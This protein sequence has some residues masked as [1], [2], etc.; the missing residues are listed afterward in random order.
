[1]CLIAVNLHDM[2]TKKSHILATEE[3]IQATGPGLG[4]LAREQQRIFPLCQLLVGCTLMLLVLQ[5]GI[6]FYLGVIAPHD[7]LS[8]TFLSPTA[9]GAF[10]LTSILVGRQERRRIALLGVVLEAVRICLH[11]LAGR[12]PVNLL[13]FPG[14]GLGVATWGFLAWQ[15]LLRRGSERR[16]ALDLL[17]ASL[18][19]TL[20]HLLLWPSIIGTIP[21]LP[22]LYDNMLIRLDAALG[23]QPASVVGIL[24]RDVPF[25]HVLHLVVYFQIPL[26]M[27]VIAALEARSG[28]R[29]GLGLIPACLIAAVIGYFLYLAMPAIGPRPYFGENFA[30]AMRQLAVLPTEPVINTTN[31]RNAMPSLHMTWALLIYLASRQHGF[32]AHA[33]GILFAFGTALATLGLGEHYFIDLVVAAPLVLLVRA[34]CAFGLPLPRPERYGALLLGAGLLLGWAVIIRGGIDP[35]GWPGLAPILMLGTVLTCFSAERLL[36]AAEQGPRV[37]E[38]R[39]PRNVVWRAE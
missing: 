21:F 33:G 24:F 22:D 36:R 39:Q 5:E 28:Q 35:T 16:N 37:V 38:Y 26:A 25:L 17:A 32:W 10:V 6:S 18:A 3:R 27:Y 9:I 2:A 4:F 29:M 14:F 12:D 34:I 7:N 19:I 31:P 30:E 13:L 8:P 20:G 11:L 15:V 23:F 1:M